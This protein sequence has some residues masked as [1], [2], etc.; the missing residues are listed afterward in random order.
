MDSVDV[1][2]AAPDPP[3]TPHR[4][5]R[6]HRCPARR[7]RGRRAPPRRLVRRSSGSSTRMRP[8]AFYTPPS[9]LPEARRGTIVRQESVDGLPTGSGRGACST[10]QPTLTA[11]RS[12][13]SGVVVAPSGEPPDGGWPVVAWAHGTTGIALSCAPVARTPSAGMSSYP[14]STELLEAGAVVAITDY[15]GLGTP[16][17]HPYLVG[18]SEGRAVL[19]S[20]RAAR[21]LLGDDTPAPRRPCSATR[22]AA[23]RRVF[24]DRLAASYAPELR[25]R[26]RRRDGAAHRPRR[27]R[28]SSTRTRRRHRAHRA[29]RST[30]WSD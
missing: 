30:S 14:S 21:S 25:P 4:P 16:G 26:R 22:K 17:P 12:P 28:S 27:A 1:P 29:W 2:A 3:T 13:V 10:R 9:A 20:I 7:R 11:R 23:T 15:P 6:R 8:P 18:E 19:D 24:A 5:R